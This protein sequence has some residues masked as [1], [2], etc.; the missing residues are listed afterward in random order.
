MRMTT[1]AAKM[2]AMAATR[3]SGTPVI[4][5]VPTT[6]ELAAAGLE[7]DV[8]SKPLRLESRPLRFFFFIHSLH[9]YFLLY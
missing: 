1:T 2:S 6:L 9:I 5:A 7:I 4:T 8:G 3:T